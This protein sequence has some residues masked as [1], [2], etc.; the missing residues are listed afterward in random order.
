MRDVR[1]TIALL[2]GA[3]ALCAPATA[4]AAT[5]PATSAHAK[6]NVRRAYAKTSSV[7]VYERPTKTPDSSLGFETGVYVCSKASGRAHLLGFDDIQGRSSEYGPDDSF[8]TAEVAGNYV[9]AQFSSGTAANSECEKYSYDDG[10]GCPQV[11]TAITVITTISGRSTQFNV[12]GADGDST[13]LAIS[14]AGA[15]AWFANGDLLAT[16]L[17]PVGRSH[18]LGRP[19]V[20]DAGTTARSLSITGLTVHW[21][22]DSGAHSAPAPAP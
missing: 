5:P 6:C 13:Q 3:M 16:R 9:A 11:V 8:L 19:R 17:R 22:D 14:S 18:L 1:T 7:V 12:A 21:F 20:L 2:C 4:A 15:L 10:A